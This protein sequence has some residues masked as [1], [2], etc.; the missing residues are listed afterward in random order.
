[1]SST[2]LMKPLHFEAIEA[3]MG[4][5]L[6]RQSKVIIGYVLCK[7]IAFSHAKCGIISGYSLF[8]RNFVAQSSHP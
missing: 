7:R 2:C 5:P 6:R 8:F 1:M 3:P 4:E